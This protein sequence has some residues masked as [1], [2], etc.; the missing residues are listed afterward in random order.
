MAFMTQ[1]GEM[2]P[3]QEARVLKLGSHKQ[4]CVCVCVCVYVCVLNV[5]MFN[6]YVF[7]MYV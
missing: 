6:V 4:L 1:E 7:N 3:D 2:A 5:Y